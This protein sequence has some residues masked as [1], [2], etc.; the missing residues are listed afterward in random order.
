MPAANET[1]SLFA[2]A[3]PSSRKTA[4]TI[5]GFTPRKTI[6]AF[7]AISLFCVVKRSPSSFS[8]CAR[9]STF[10]SLARIASGVQKFF[11]SNPRMTEPASFPRAN[12]AEST[13]IFLCCF[14][15]C[16]SDT[17]LPDRNLP[18]F[19][20]C[21]Q[22]NFAPLILIAADKMSAGRTG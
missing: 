14:Y 9:V 11:K 3:S 15:A 20:L 7:A 13:S 16:H 21:G 19:S 2:I 17:R 10:G 22:T 6:S 1:T 18:T 8:N 4:S 5:C 12:E